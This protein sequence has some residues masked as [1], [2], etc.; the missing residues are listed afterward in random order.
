MSKVYR[1]FEEETD[2]PS[3]IT[4]ISLYREDSKVSMD[5][6]KVKVTGDCDKKCFG[7]MGGKA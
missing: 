5:L 7:A 2:S 3:Q 1:L 4:A 6:G